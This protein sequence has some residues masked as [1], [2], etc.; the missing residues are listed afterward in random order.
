MF[1]IKRFIDLRFGMLPFLLVAFVSGC[2]GGGLDPI[3][4]TPG[5]GALPTVT[6]TTPVAS[7]PPVTGIA[8]NSLVSAAFSKD[9]APETLN[10]DS[11]SLSCPSGTPV[12]AAVSYDAAT[13]VATL[14]PAA[15]LPPATLCV[16]TLTT[17][18]R[19]TAG[20]ALASKLVWSFVT[21]PAPDLTAPTVVMMTPA[22]GAGNVANNTQVTAVFSEDM[23]AA[24]INGSSFSVTN[25]SL[26][27]TV[28]GTVSYAPTGRTAVFTPTT[29][30]SL[31]ANSRYSATITTAAADLAGNTLAL[32]AVWTFQ[33]APEPDTTRPTIVLT[34]PADNAT[35]V[36]ISTGI[37]ATFSEDMNPATLTSGSFTVVNT[38][39]GTA[40]PG[41][42]SYA[43]NGR[44]LV[45]TPTTP[46]SLPANSAFTATVTTTAADLAGNALAANVVW[47]F[48]TGSAP[49]ADRPT[50][51]GTVPAPNAGNVATNSAVSATFSEDMNPTS[52]SGNSFT[53]VNNT[54]GAPVAGLVG[55]S[56]SGR[57]AIFT[58]TSAAGLAANSRYTATITG[59]AADLSGNTLAAN[60]TW[61]FTTTAAPDTTRPT[62][63]A[64]SPVDQAVGV[65]SNSAISASFSED[66]DPNS[67]SANSFSLVNTTLGT[68]VPGT[69]GYAAT[70]RSLVFT[71]SSAGGLAASSSFRA[72][73]ST[74]ARDLAGNPLAA[75]VAWTFTTAAA[76]DTTRPTVTTTVPANN[77]LAVAN[78]SAI[79]AGFSEAMNPATLTSASFT[80]FNTALG[81]PVAGTVSYSATGRTAVFTPSTPATLA[82]DTRFTATITTAA[83]DLA[84]NALAGNV[85]W[86]F[87]TAA[88][89]D[90]SR[91]A[92][93][94]TV[95]LSNSSAVATNSRLTASFSE[96]MNP[97][98]IS[99]TSFTLVNSSMGT[100]VPGSVSYSVA[101]RTATFTPANGAQLASSS[102]FTVRL[103]TAMTDLAGN[104]LAGNTALASSA[105]DHVWTFATAD[106]ADATAPTVTAVSPLDGSTA[107]CRGS[108]VSATFSEP[109]DPDTFGSNSFTVSD[110]G[111][112]VAG[113]VSY[114]AQSRV[115]SFAPADAA[116]FA[117]NRQFVATVRSGSAGVQDL[118]GNPIATDRVW[119]FTTSNQACF[120]AVNL[121]SAGTFGAFG[122]TAGV[123]NQ[124][125]NSLVGGNL[126]STAV[127]T[128]VTGFHDASNVYTETPLNVAAVNGSIY[129]APPAPGTTT[130][131]AIA[132]Q[133]RADAQTAYNALAALPPGGD[134]GAGQLGGL[135]LPG[136][137]YTAA[138]GSFAIT[139]GDLTLDA[140]GNPDAV[141]VFQSATALTVGQPAAPRR[142]LLINGA[143]ASRVFW[144]VGSAA[145]I[146]DRSTMAGTII[147][148]A[149]VTISTAG[150]TAQTT[151]IGRAL[152]LIASVTMVNTTV[153]LP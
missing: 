145:R 44:T 139:A 93:V 67:L 52:L 81:T 87:T 12:R 126:G 99:S 115:A 21:E 92:V 95:P 89:P 90:T 131:L 62:V 64:T 127:C 7:S 13:R 88:L 77:A 36:A 65:A 94:S 82:P 153:V 6:A 50:V 23:R 57:T 69:V 103:S 116:G 143:Q 141:W 51:I 18:V 104:A 55:Y 132:T 71:P 105:G 138:G 66:M 63:I 22:D 101:A 48:S 9:M 53:L 30:G 129:C 46:A 54:L 72:T 118:A 27:T 32:P 133:A 78:N 97:S 29:P 128:A 60:V 2:G 38:S 119:R 109:M 85:V 34:A 142:V 79:S 86:G 1:A 75:S 147:A 148:T 19:D 100:S 125:I 151:L 144:Q 47:R 31:A 124:G 14:T 10:S 113:S 58:P 111:T 42:V 107:V 123:T 91:P 134:P 5:A 150:Q 136:A 137:V 3:L 49:D 4:G 35:S 43:T 74:A 56:A 120:A 24:S 45:F 117:A 114:N 149:G 59:A 122:G 40:I 15:A 26:G 83:T 84:G 25:T 70:G 135:V 96:D 61:T 108:P 106:L 102:S 121:R 140:Q 112:A 80:L 28:P 76:P 110:N 8:L 146:E 39:L 37:T 68:S 41:R 33:T 16:A 98:S 130:T 73:L 152:G 11:F 20:F 17:A